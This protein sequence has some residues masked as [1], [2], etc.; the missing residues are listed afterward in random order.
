MLVPNRG[1]DCPKESLGQLARSG[2][3]GRTFGRASSTGSHTPKGDVRGI[4]GPD[5]VG[6]SDRMQR[7]SAAVSMLGKRLIRPGYG[8]EDSRSESS[9]AP[10]RVKGGRRAE[11]RS[12]FSGLALRDKLH[13]RD[14]LVKACVARAES[15]TPWSTTGR[16]RHERSRRAATVGRRLRVVAD[17][18]P[19]TPFRSPEPSK[20]DSS[21]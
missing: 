20:T 18:V 15:S 4:V 13:E 1:A 11:A 6:E 19:A 5:E 16:L 12:A 3:L 8:P 14:G 17:T 10:R 2:D 9:W 21:A 7:R